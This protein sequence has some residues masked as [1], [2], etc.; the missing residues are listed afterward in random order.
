[1]FKKIVSKLPFNPSLLSHLR[2]YDNKLKKELRLRVIGLTMLS[3]VIILQSFAAIS[4]PQDNHFYSPNNLLNVSSDNQSEIYKSCLNN[5]SG[6][7]NILSF[8]KLNCN[9]LKTASKI[10]LGLFSNNNGLY[11]LNRLSY[12]PNNEKN[13]LI[14]DQSLYIR[15]L[16]FGDALKT[17]TIKV[18][19]LKNTGVY[20]EIN[21][22][23][24]IS[25]KNY[26]IRGQKQLICSTSEKNSCFYYYIAARDVTSGKSDVNNS[27][28]SSG[29]VVAY[30][31]FIKNT[32]LY[33]ITNF[34]FSVNFSNALAYST[35]I[36]TY[37]G[38]FNH[39]L[40]SY[41]VKAM[42]SNQALTE[43]IVFR[44]KTSPPEVAVSASDPNYDSGKMITTFGNTISINVPKSAATYY[45]LSVNNSLFSIS[46]RLS[47]FILFILLVIYLYF[48]FRIIL[49]REE[50]NIIKK[51][52]SD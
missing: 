50:I 9:D 29:D 13:I 48:I 2:D 30:T 15:K 33:K 7:E 4:P 46:S 23:N 31:L 34:N 3:L 24:I 35:L 52:H 22:G 47:V 26:L 12:D 32:S 37:G 5:T 25:S 44:V 43:E 16:S 51:G 21:S 11:S 18:F 41:Y 42:N 40:I 14:N 20:I 19:R 49:I 10:T 45:E 28:V 8:Y 38:N 39:G 27:T 17:D 1:M 36:H 6:Y